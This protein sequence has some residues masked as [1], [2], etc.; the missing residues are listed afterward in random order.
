[1][2]ALPVHDMVCEVDGQASPPTLLE[3]EGSV[4]QSIAM[5]VVDRAS[6]HRGAEAESS[7]A[8]MTGA[9]S[10]TG[11]MTTAT[12]NDSGRTLTTCIGNGICTRA[13][14]SSATSTEYTAP[15]K[16]VTSP[17]PSPKGRIAGQCRVDPGS[18]MSAQ[19][20]RTSRK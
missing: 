11:W 9:G 10:G 3:G 18:G 8:G 14:C 7:T 2:F 13:A 1:M 15:G 17:N 4:F 6:L 16:R 12:R 20:C 5:A 19:P